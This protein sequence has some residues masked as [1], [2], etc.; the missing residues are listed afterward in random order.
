MTICGSQ[1][2]PLTIATLTSNIVRDAGPSTA[3]LIVRL[4]GMPLR[5]RLRL[6]HKIG[7]ALFQRIAERRRNGSNYFAVL[8]ID[9]NAGF[10][11]VGQSSP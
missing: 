2:D 9:V 6:F 1:R 4:A 10:L 11:R 5:R 3:R 8:I 7:L